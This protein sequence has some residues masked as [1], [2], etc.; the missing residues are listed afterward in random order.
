MTLDKEQ[1]IANLTPRQKITAGIFLIILIIIIWQ[2][3]GLFSGRGKTK[4]IVNA[5]AN[6]Q[7][8]AG[9]KGNAPGPEE[10]TPHAAELPK[11]AAAHFPHKI[12]SSQLFNK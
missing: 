12:N 4:P 7:Q 8:T 3:I 6:M 5:S 10:M 1:A 9:M 11:P 2:L